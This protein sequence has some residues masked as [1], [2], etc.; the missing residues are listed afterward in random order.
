MSGVRV[1]KIVGEDV[2]QGITARHERIRSVEDVQRELEYIYAEQKVS[3]GAHDVERV[4]S[5]AEARRTLELIHKIIIV[6]E[7]KGRGGDVDY[8]SVAAS[9]FEKVE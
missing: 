1:R 5:L 9:I 3:A 4:K 2:G 6:E 7:A 8:Q